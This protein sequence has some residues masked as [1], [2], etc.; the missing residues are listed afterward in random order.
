MDFTIFSEK[1]YTMYMEIDNKKQWGLYLL[2][3]DIMTKIA[4]FKS[5]KLYKLGQKYCLLFWNI[6]FRSGDIQVSKVCKLP[7]DN[8]I[9]SAKFW[10]NMIIKDMSVNLYQKYVIFLG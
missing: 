9:H 4:S 7:S 5:E 1:H 6:S 10:L 2:S 3:S 8:V